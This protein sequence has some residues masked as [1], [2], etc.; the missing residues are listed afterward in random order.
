MSQIQLNFTLRVASKS[1]KTVHL[2]GSWDGYKA[3]LPLSRDTSSSKPQ[4]KG[5]FRFMPPTLQ[6]GSRYWYY[7]VLDA[8]SVTYDPK[9]EYVIEPTT[10]RTL[11]ILKIPGGPSSTAASVH[12]SSSSHH[13]TKDMRPSGHSSHSSHRHSRTAPANGRSL[14]PSQI[15]HPLPSRPYETKKFS[16]REMEALSRRYA[17]QRL[18][19]SS[20]SDGSSDEDSAGYSSGGYSPVPSLSSSRTSANSSPS[21]VSSLGS[22]G[23]SSC[24]C[25]RFAVTRD[26]VRY[27]LDCKGLVC[28]GSEDGSSC[29]SDS[30]SESEEEVRYRK[31]SGRHGSSRHHGSSGKSHHSSSGKSRRHGLVVRR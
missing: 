7:Y 16:S 31:G 13:T 25:E 24:T 30:S 22:G 10:G 3:N 4:F 28:Q 18:V 29:S 8:H 11:N 12:S 26:G 20:S 6:P 23:R 19:E 9:Q 1:C 17:A 15:Q 5:T 2:V 27:K 14:S 21:S